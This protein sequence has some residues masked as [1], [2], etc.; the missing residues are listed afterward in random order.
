MVALANLSTDAEPVVEGIV[1]PSA[2]GAVIAR[3]A[4]E[5]ANSAIVALA[6]ALVEFEAY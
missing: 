5:V 3:F 4:S 2:N 1:T 6:G